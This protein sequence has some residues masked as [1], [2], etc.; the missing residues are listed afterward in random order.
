[1][2]FSETTTAEIEKKNRLI[3]GLE[4]KSKMRELSVPTND[5][6]VKGM[7]LSPCC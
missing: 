1:M 6:L 3:A 2:A 4:E 7:L 5:E